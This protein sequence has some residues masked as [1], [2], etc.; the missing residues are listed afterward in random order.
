MKTIMLAMLVT[1]GAITLAPMQ[2]GASSFIAPK[3]LR[4]MRVLT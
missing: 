3:N 1:S 2:A 4:M